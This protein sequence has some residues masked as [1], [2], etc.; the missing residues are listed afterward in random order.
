MSDRVRIVLDADNS[1]G[2]AWALFA[3]KLEEGGAAEY[4]VE[5]M[6]MAFFMGAAQAYAMTMAHARGS[7][8][9]FVDTMNLIAAE[10][11]GVLPRVDN[12]SPLRRRR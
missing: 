11:D 2:E 1:L 5:S 8:E 3:E 6:Q 7:R 9:E 12:V 10:I 4:Q